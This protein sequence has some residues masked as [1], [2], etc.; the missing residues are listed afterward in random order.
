LENAGSKMYEDGKAGEVTANRGANPS[1]LRPLCVK[2]EG[3]CTRPKTPGKGEKETDALV[4]QYLK[5]G[6]WGLGKGRR[7]GGRSGRRLEVRRGQ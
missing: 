7:F 6:E 5:G 3:D 4:V 2:I 1:M